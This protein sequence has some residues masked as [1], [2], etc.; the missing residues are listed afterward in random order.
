[1]NRHADGEADE[2]KSVM[3]LCHIIHFICRSEA[4]ELDRW[5]FPECCPLETSQ[6]LLDATR[7]R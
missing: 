3:N 6:E 2:G 5:K 7:G 1:M 4:A